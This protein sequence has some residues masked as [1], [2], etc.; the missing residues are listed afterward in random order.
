VTV[1]FPHNATPRSLSLSKRASRVELDG[2]QLHL[3]ENLD[4]PAARLT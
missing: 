4:G 2:T 3:T 1:R